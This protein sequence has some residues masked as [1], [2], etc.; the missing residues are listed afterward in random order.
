MDNILGW[1]VEIVVPT[2]FTCINIQMV[3]WYVT[4]NAP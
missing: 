1:D 2:E 4:K 3:R